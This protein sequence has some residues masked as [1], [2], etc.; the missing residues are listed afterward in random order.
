MLLLPIVLI[1]LKFA[2]VNIFSLPWSLFEPLL[3][4]VILYTFFHSFDTKD[5]VLYALFCGFLGEIFSADAFGI[6]IIA[7]LAV[8]F[9]VALICVV[10]YRENRLFL[11][12]VVFVGTWLGN[13]VIVF[14]KSFFSH[15]AAGPAIGPF[16]LG[17]IAESAGNT[18]LV[19]LLDLFSKR[20][21]LEFIK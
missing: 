16:L 3:A 6:H 12:P 10:I 11:F 17:G 7:Y 20:C 1:F 2:F 5:Y 15:A 19:Y 18:L 14:L 13:A 4:C 21:G 8:A 9:C